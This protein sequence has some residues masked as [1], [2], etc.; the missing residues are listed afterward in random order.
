MADRERSVWR[1]LLG[2]VLVALTAGLAWHWRQSATDRDNLPALRAREAAYVTQRNR[3]WDAYAA[4]VADWRAGGPVGRPPSVPVQPGADDEEL[5]RVR[6]R[7]R[8][9]QGDDAGQPGP[10]R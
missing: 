8:Q 10:T 7:I 4:A 1:A 9:I 5:G 2:A 3:A 6:E